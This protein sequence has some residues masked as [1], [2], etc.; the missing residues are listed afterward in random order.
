MRLEER[1]EERGMDAVGARRRGCDGCAD[2]GGRVTRP[3]SQIRDCLRQEKRAS[4]RLAAASSRE[5]ASLSHEAKN[6][7]DR[8][9]R[10]DSRH[11]EA[12]ASFAALRL[13]DDLDTPRV[14]PQPFSPS[15]V[16]LTLPRGPSDVGLPPTAPGRR[17]KPLTRTGKVTAP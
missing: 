9:R 11:T 15:A 14:G 5:P 12:R 2:N 1:S 10:R 13:K 16:T 6:V 4:G 7:V 3:S 17:M 8:T